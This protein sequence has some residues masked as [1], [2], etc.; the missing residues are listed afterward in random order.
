MTANHVRPIPT[1]NEAKE[2]EMSIFCGC[3][4]REIVLL[5]RAS[6]ADQ[7]PA[8]EYL[9]V[10]SKYHSAPFYLKEFFHG[11]VVTLHEIAG[12]VHVVHHESRFQAASA[13]RS[14]YILPQFGFTAGH[15]LWICKSCKEIAN[16]HLPNIQEYLAR[17]SRDYN[18][19]IVFAV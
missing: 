2:R 17:R 9:E 5:T 13:E 8:K 12:R 4:P 14:T 6:V 11:F 10:P 7:V 18:T 15:S 3:C 19:P 1:M 16:S